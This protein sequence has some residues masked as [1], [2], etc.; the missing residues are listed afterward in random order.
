MNAVVKAIQCRAL[1]TVWVVEPP[2]DLT[3]HQPQQSLSCKGFHLE[4][5]RVTVTSFL[6]TPDLRITSSGD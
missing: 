4:P 5:P 3:H 1:P 2:P 6:H